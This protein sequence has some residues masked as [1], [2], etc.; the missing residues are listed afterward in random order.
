MFSP[1]ATMTDTSTVP[2]F[3][4]QKADIILRSADNVDFKMFR[5]L[6]SFASPF[7]DGMFSLPSPP[8]EGNNDDM[9]D[10]LP[11]VQLSESSET[12]EN[13]LLF[14]HPWC[15]PVLQNL[16]EVQTILGAATK[17]DM[18]GVASRVRRILVAPRFI[19]KEPLRVFAIALSYNLD[20]E[21]RLAA[22]HTLKFPF[23]PRE[24][25]S[26]LEGISAG[27]LH[28]LQAY[29]YGCG[30]AANAVA[31]SFAWISL[32]SFIHFGARYCRECS[33]NEF[34]TIQDSRQ[35]SARRWW[36]AYMRDAGEALMERPCG[37]TVRR[38]D[39]TFK[40]LKAASTCAS[41]RE[42]AFS[43]MREFMDAFDNEVESTVSTVRLF[44]FCQWSVNTHLCYLARIDH[45]A[46]DGSVIAVPSSCTRYLH[47]YLLFCSFGYHNVFI[48]PSTVQAC[49]SPRHRRQSSIQRPKRGCDSANYR[50][51]RLSSVQASTFLG[52]SFFP[53]KVCPDGNTRNECAV[54]DERRSDGL[55]RERHQCY[56]RTAPQ[57]LL[58][59]MGTRPQ[60]RHSGAPSGRAGCVEKVR[61][62]TCDHAVRIHPSG[63]SV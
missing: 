56:N 9:K 18:Q 22:R 51:C 1:L 28:R 4:V 14:C 15:A 29:H 19:E 31:T 59:E 39:I 47:G 13:L 50:Q 3:D 57:V 2:R 7:F 48:S 58:S 33:L 54:C 43:E 52:F 20:D 17:Y 26:E 42:T 32:D 24:Y 27:A 5:S 49:H 10:G 55:R 61:D 46:V 21:A 63:T 30:K 25:V 35:I 12:V 8:P 60:T 11:V 41:C 44:F 34:I 36:L 38:P 40:A 62:E 6:L 16:Q 45:S 53:R 37:S 23:F